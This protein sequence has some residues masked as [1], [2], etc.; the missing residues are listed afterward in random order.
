MRKVIHLVKRH[1]RKA[2]R[3]LL[4]HFVPHERNQHNPHAL[5]HRVLVGYSVIL[6]LL[7]A[8]ALIVPVVLPSSSL[9]SS[10]VTPQNIVSLTNQT[11]QNLNL[12]ALSVNEKLSQAASAKAQDMVANQYFAHTSPAGVTPWSWFQQAG[13]KYLVAGENLAVHFTSAEGV[14]EGWM[15]SPSHRANIVNARYSEIG[16]GVA[17]GEFEGYQ[18]TFVVQMFGLPVGAPEAP[19]VTVASAPSGLPKIAVPSEG[20]VA[21]AEQTPPVTQPSQVEPES[22]PQPE[23][24]IETELPTAPVAEQPVVPAEEAP[25]PSPKLVM[26]ESNITVT[27]QADA[28]HV[29]V[30]IV[31][32]SK[33]TAHLAGETGELTQEA[34]TPDVWQGTIPYHL[35][36]MSRGGERL[37]VQAVSPSGQHENF[38]LAWVAPQAQTQQVYTFNE[39]EARYAKVF[40]LTIP[41][42]QDEV[43]QVYFYFMVFLGA[44]LLINILVKVRIQ[45]LS[46]IGHTAF[47]L[48]LALLLMAV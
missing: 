18:T 10:A 9:Y 14:T 2:G 7:K 32:A 15:A 16:V 20:Q 47:V 17:M 13:Y 29:R 34:G 8:L 31:G 45:K 27:Q 30:T 24:P 33:V 21:A 48:A 3:H 35:A 38:T 26:D 28:Y 4:D 42:M 46:V 1:S 37:T 6:V 11:R 44:A 5:K 39:G 43:R 41:N 23:P 25:Q 22:Q 12:T 36:T 19:A 40:G